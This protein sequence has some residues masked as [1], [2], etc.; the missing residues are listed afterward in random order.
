MVCQYSQKFVSQKESGNI[1]LIFLS[2]KSFSGVINSFDNARA[3]SLSSVNFLSVCASC[4]HFSEACKGSNSD[5]ACLTNNTHPEQRRPASLS[6]EHPG[7][8]PTYIQ[9]GYPFLFRHACRSLFGHP[10]FRRQ[11]PPA[12][13]SF[14]RR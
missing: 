3:E 5:H 6:K 2:S 13:S 7:T 10:F 9:N 12:R 8:Y 14:S 4:P 11:L 1:S